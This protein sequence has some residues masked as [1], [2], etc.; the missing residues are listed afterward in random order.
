MSGDEAFRRNAQQF[1]R[2]T[3]EELVIAR[4]E[5]VSMPQDPVIRDRLGEYA[6]SAPAM[7]A[8]ID[9]VY[10]KMVELLACEMAGE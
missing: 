7:N 4:Y 6:L 5:P 2:E 3:M 9:R 8:M 1:L 10:G